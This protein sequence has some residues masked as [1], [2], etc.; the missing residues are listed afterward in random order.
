M[1]QHRSRSSQRCCSLHHR[2]SK[3][4][5]C[6]LPG[7]VA[8]PGLLYSALSLS[9]L[10][11]LS[12]VSHNELC[13]W[14]LPLSSVPPGEASRQLFC[15][16]ITSATSPVFRLFSSYTM[17]HRLSARPSALTAKVRQDGAN[18]AQVL[19]RCEAVRVLQYQSSKCQLYFSVL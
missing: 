4:G 3:D 6:R 14:K 16:H 12:T 9:L 2:R 1:C 5:P 8:N 11:V 19:H 13:S 7:D 10:S 15:L 17:L 18:L